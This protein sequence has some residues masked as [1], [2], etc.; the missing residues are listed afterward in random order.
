MSLKPVLARSE[1]TAGA[2]LLLLFFLIAAPGARAEPPDT[3]KIAGLKEE[4][5][6]LKKAGRYKE[7]VGFVPY[8]NF[9]GRADIIFFSIEPTASIWEFWEWPMAIRWNRFFDLV[10]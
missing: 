7:A 10:K 6:K 1:F 3:A 4:F 8:E 2:I 5:G 9:V